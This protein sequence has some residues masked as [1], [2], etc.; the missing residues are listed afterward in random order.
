[1]QRKALRKYLLGAAAIGLVTAVLASSCGSRIDGTATAGEIDVRTL[2]V[3]KYPVLPV[4]AYY[5]YRHNFSYGQ[6]L[7]SMRLADALILG[8][9]VDPT[10]KYGDWD[11]FTADTLLSSF[12]DNVHPALTE[13]K[14]LY[15][16]ATGSTDIE[17]FGA[18][19]LSPGDDAIADYQRQ[20]RP[21]HFGM[22][23][24][25]FPDATAAAKAAEAIER[26]DFEVAPDQNQRVGLDK[27]PSAR[28]HWRP[29]VPTLGTVV[30][31]GSYVVNLQVG[32]PDPDLPALTALATRV[33]DA[34]L[35][36]LDQLPPLSPTEVL[37][38]NNDPS[39]VLERALNTNRLGGPEPEHSASYGLQGF[40]HVRRDS[41]A[42]RDLYQ[43]SGIEKIGIGWDAIVF[44]ARDTT[45]AEKFQSAMFDGPAFA[46]ADS[47]T[48]VPDTTCT[49]NKTTTT[50]T[51]RF[52]CAVRY[53]HF[54]A[55]I[56][57]HQLHD[58][59]QRAAAQYATFANAQ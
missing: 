48:T 41:F 8:T 44:R 52:T 21:T 55:S 23:V 30:A 43:Q 51:K 6:R 56:D 35:P 53:R 40:F 4:S 10:L 7:A 16:F 1:M 45:G 3:G 27:Y 5:Q 47:P 24:M 13:H 34:Q 25:Q 32:K 26:L 39:G 19:V 2:D 59:H 11:S 28:S 14:L 17:T 58:A 31:H 54:V 57:S 50:H 29:G 12:S 18:F 15:G 36:W 49:E 38:L 42:Q 33:L 22:S 37:M 46:P 20:Y 9:D